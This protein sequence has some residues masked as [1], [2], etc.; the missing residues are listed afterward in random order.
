MITPEGR[1]AVYHHI[2]AEYSLD[3]LGSAQIFYTAAQALGYGVR[4][5]EGMSFEYEEPVTRAMTISEEEAQ[6]LEDLQEAFY[7]SPVGILVKLVDNRDTFLLMSNIPEFMGVIGKR[8]FRVPPETRKRAFMKA[9]ERER[10][11]RIRDAQKMDL[12]QL[13]LNI[14]SYKPNTRISDY[15][16]RLK[17]EGLTAISEEEL[18]K[19]SLK[20]LA[21]I[22]N[23]TRNLPQDYL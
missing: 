22:A 18:F 15:Y 2:A 14:T 7:E 23:L 4:N 20:Q 10:E 19:L 5:E 9:Y 8:L 1:E 16:L 21:N 13:L 6:R 11:L 3:P 12:E 17:A